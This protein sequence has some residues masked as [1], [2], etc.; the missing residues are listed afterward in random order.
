VAA[1]LV[2]LLAAAP[3][4]AQAP[5]AGPWGGAEHLARAGRT[6]EALHRFRRI[7]DEHPG[8]VEARLWLARLLRWTGEREAAEREYRRSLE[9]APDHVDALTG[10]AAL[11]NVRGAFDEASTLLDRAEALTPASADVFA[12]RA[13]GLRLA[14]RPSR[15]EGYYLRARALSPDDADIR[16][17]LEQVRRLT[18]HRVEASVLHES[19]SGLA[20]GAQAADVRLDV[21]AADHLRFNGR[22]QADT[23]ASR[24]DVRAGGGLEWRARP[25]L[26]IRGSTL[27]G[28][29]ADVMARSETVV[30]L[31]HVRG[32]LE[33]A[34]AARYMAFA[35]AGVW[36]VSPAAA[37]WLDDRTA[38][39]VR[40]YGSRTA[41][42][43]RDAVIDHSGAV[44]V[45]HNLRPRLWLDAG[46]ARGFESFERLSAE[47]LGLFRADTV[48]GGVL[49]HLAGLQSLS[50]AIEYQRRDDERTMIRITAGVVHRF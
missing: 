34:V 27:L 12:T 47:R 7:V 46:Y 45:R 50:A 31:D 39:T 43:G 35:T 38:V 36:I 17:G 21:R 22:I 44:R 8:D 13:Q 32:R 9:R 30:E 18:R 5:E 26:T 11:L 33:P 14:G 41:F 48:S 16:Q 29:G 4:P 2:F 6:T 1:L 15:A 20:A 37:W 3:A 40:Y 42:A 25:A 49:F 10:L 28:P 24:H 19:V 23:R